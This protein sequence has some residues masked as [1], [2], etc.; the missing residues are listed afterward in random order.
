MQRQRLRCRDLGHCFYYTIL[1]NNGFGKE[2]GSL[3][4]L[5]PSLR[6]VGQKI[7]EVQW[8]DSLPS[9][10]RIWVLS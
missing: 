2:E 1:R 7:P 8:L 6:L 3:I 5:S 9:L 4:E 10:P